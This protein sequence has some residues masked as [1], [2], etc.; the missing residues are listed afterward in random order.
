[1]ITLTIFDLM[2]LAVVNLFVFLPFNHIRGKFHQNEN[3]YV[4]LQSV[5]QILTQILDQ[6]FFS[7]FEGA[8]MTPEKLQSLP[9]F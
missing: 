5:L 2:C 7:C 4:F 6:L 9:D 3:L 1:M 8:N